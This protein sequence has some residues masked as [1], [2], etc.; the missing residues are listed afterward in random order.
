MLAE[1][2]VGYQSKNCFV[3]ALSPGGV[4]VGAQIAM[5]IHADLA[6]LLTEDISLP[7]EKD[8]LAAVSTENTFTYNKLF[9]KGEIEEF[10]A[11]YMSYIEQERMQKVHKLHQLMGKDGEI[12]KDL[13]RRHVVILVS[14]GFID[15]FPLDVADDFL[16][17]IKTK[18][19]VIASP[20]ASVAAVDR[21]H[22][23]GDEVHCLSTVA[24]YINTDHY[25]TDNTIPDTDGLLK[26]IR[27]TPIHWFR[28]ANMQPTSG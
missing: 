14:D 18:R 4:I 23:L 25:Y 8:P 7:G 21:M 11:D 9:S 28:N 10:T 6:M 17:P 22:L 13:L 2:L 1:L 12:K 15:G 20:L 3:V 26:V 24:N 19:L 16:K 5:K 27:N